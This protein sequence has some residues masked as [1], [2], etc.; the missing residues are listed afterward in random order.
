MTLASPDFNL[1]DF[2]KKV[3]NE[4]FGRGC[5]L[6]LSLIPSLS[7][8]GLRRNFSTR[9]L[10]MMKQKAIG[11]GYQRSEKL[12]K[13]SGFITIVLFMIFSSLKRQQEEGPREAAVRRVRL[14]R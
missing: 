12:A 2:L 7:A 9:T 11:I 10:A 5:L 1:L 4:E 6:A 14:S 13:F 3:S 8:R